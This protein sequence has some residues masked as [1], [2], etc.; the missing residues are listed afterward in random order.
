MF[1][2]FLLLFPPDLII[3]FGDRSLL[4]NLA[5]L[6]SIF[7]FFK[8]IHDSACLSFQVFSFFIFED[9]LYV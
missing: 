1:V 7:C 8:E 2:L 4:L 5:V 9:V 3:L 6:L